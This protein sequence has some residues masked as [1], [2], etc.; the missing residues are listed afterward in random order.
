MSTIEQEL[1][2]F[3]VPWFTIRH[4]NGRMAML[5]SDLMEAMER[6]EKIVRPTPRKSDLSPI[7]ER[8]KRSSK[9]IPDYAN[10]KGKKR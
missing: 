9:A 3:G 5:T 7:G 4:P 1:D 8:R 6:T 2:E 10:T